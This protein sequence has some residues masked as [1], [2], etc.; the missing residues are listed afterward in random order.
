MKRALPQMNTDQ[1]GFKHGEL[2]EKII[3]VFYDVYNELGHGFLEC[4]YAEAMF[5]ALREAGLKVARQLDIPVWF[6]NRRIGEFRADLLVDDVVILE[7]K[8]ARRIEPVFEAQLLHYLR[9]TPVEIGLLFNFGPKP[10][11]RR[12]RF[13]NEL[14]QIRENLRE[15][16]AK[17]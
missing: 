7:L 10:E 2:T 17:N 16:V 14:K 5:V 1:S 4:V 13:D 9:A 3:G 12:L 11:F 15:S 6:R 8:S